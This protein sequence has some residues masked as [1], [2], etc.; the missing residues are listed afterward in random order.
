MK[1]VQENHYS[2]EYDYR[3]GSPHLKF[4]HLYES[5]MG[6]VA[7]EI[8]GMDGVPEVLEIGA[9]DGS[10]AERLLALGCEVTG[11][12][13][14]GDQVDEMSGRFETN[15][16]FRAVHDPDGDL[17]VLG[18]S[19]FDLILYSSVLHHIPDYLGHI[20]AAAAEHLEQDGSLVSI[21]DPLW[22]PRVPKKSRKLTEAF[23]LTWRIGQGDLVRGVKTRSRRLFSGLSEEEPGDAVEYHVVRDGVDEEAIVE[24]LDPTFESV[25]LRKYWSS[26]GTA[27]QKLGEKLGYTNTF[28]I[29]ASGFEGPRE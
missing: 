23:Y 26:Q 25:E 27:Q 13:M 19:R 11:T 22:Y 7:D 20:E 6:R 8:S 15:D 16:R 28:A 12:E 29:F 18:D 14:S 4:R 24:T 3:S 10:V 9:G 5:L 2:G 1:S 21:Q 17:K